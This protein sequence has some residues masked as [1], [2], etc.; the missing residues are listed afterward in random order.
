[1]AK[2]WKSDGAFCRWLIDS[3]YAGYTNSKIDLVVSEG[4]AIYMWESYLEGVRQ[5]EIKAKDSIKEGTFYVEK[6]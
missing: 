6:K 2:R 4:L 5:G 1:M 3:G